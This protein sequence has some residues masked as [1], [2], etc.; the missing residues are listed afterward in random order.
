MNDD[1]QIPV[2][3]QNCVVSNVGTESTGKH[4]VAKTHFHTLDPF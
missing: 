3:Q 2:S 4:I 1:D